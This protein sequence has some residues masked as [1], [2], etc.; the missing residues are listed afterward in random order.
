M[1]D[2]QL[3]GVVAG[4]G[5][6]HRRS[7]SDGILIK[8]NHVSIGGI[9]PLLR[10]AEGTRSPLHRVEIEVQSLEQLDQ[11][12]AIGVDVVMLDNFDLDMLREGIQRVRAR[13]PLTKIEVSGGITLESV[14]S[15]A[16]L[17]VDYISVGLLTHSVTALNMSLDLSVVTDQ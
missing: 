14:R 9:E 10:R 7:L 13:A 4:G 5:F 1:R 16:E 11:V 8:D 2:L 17:G 3:M 12:L 15:I 6:V